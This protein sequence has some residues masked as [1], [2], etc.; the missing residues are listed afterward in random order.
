[1]PFEVTVSKPLSPHPDTN[2]KAPK[3]RSEREKSD[4]ESEEGLLR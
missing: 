3:K 4:R 2:S 1:M